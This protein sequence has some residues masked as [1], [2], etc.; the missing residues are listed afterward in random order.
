[1]W[2][3]MS[4]KFLCEHFRQSPHIFSAKFCISGKDFL[5]NLTL[6]RFINPFNQSSPALSLATDN[7]FGFIF[8]TG[9]RKV[10]LFTLFQMHPQ[11]L[12]PST[13]RLQQPSFQNAEEKVGFI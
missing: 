7:E 3:I 10:S 13:D 2:V 1:M 8:K 6:C 4:L 5:N 9:N 12:L 11:Y